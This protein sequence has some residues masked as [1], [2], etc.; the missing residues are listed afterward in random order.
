M[1]IGIGGVSRAGKTLLSQNLKTQLHKKVGEVHLDDYIRSSSHW[2]FFM[3]YPFFYLSI[4][5]QSFDMEHPKTI[6]FDS[7]YNDIIKSSQ[8]NEVVIAEGFLITYDARIKSL[9]DRYIHIDISKNVFIQRRTHDSRNGSL[10]YAHHVWR[11]FMKYGSNNYA[12]LKHIIVN[13]DKGI[14]TKAVLQ[15]INSN[16]NSALSFS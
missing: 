10:W 3:R 4:F 9:I 15:F 16:Q 8:E 6:D 7:L 14:D 11:S 5:H 12:D 13:G 1:I 2:D